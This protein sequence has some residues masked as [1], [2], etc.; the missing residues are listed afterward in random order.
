[1][2]FAIYTPYLPYLDSIEK[3]DLY[4]IIKFIKYYRIKKE[5]GLLTFDLAGSDSLGTDK[6]F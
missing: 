5:P 1:V 3:Q 6:N 2:L 4:I